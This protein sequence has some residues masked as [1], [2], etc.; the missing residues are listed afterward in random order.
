MPNVVRRVVKIG[1][2]LL[3]H[4]GLCDDL[5]RWHAR[6]SPAVTLIVVGGGK[7]VEAIADQQ[8]RN[9]AL[10]D[11]AV[12]WLSIRAMQMNAQLLAGLYETSRWIADPADIER[13]TQCDLPHLVDPWAFMQLDARSATPLPASW[14]VSSDSIA[15][16]LAE[17][18]A[19][20]ELVLL[21]SA[22]P[23]NVGA[24]D[25]YVDAYFAE[26]SIRLKSIR[27]VNLRDADF[28]EVRLR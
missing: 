21:K 24:P 15:A 26:A 6:Q 17:F 18:A 20:D 19:A 10:N 2:S 27:F 8:L 5:R 7:L 3:T 16:R 22:L 1:G 9:P 12:H 11:V 13:L 23:Q 28:A 25:D 14:D 4:N